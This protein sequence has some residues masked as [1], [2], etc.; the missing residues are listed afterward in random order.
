MEEPPILSMTT[1]LLHAA[2][3]SRIDDS[4]SIA[5]FAIEDSLQV[6]KQRRYSCCSTRCAACFLL[7]HKRKGG[8]R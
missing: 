6:M 2:V 4:I 8:G 7:T 3:V 1:F 5:T